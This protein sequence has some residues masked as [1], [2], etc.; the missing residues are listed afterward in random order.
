MKVS[1]IFVSMILGASLCTQA[2]A[3]VRFFSPAECEAN[4]KTRCHVGG[5]FLVRSALDINILATFDTKDITRPI[6]LKFSDPDGNPMP[7]W[8]PISIS[9]GDTE[10]IHTNK[11]R[12]PR[13]RISRPTNDLSLTIEYNPTYSGDRNCEWVRMGTVEF[14]KT[15]KDDNYKENWALFEIHLERELESIEIWPS[16]SGIRGELRFKD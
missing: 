1:G 3:N 9:V 4:A 7:D 16:L 15:R 5:I 8:K 13:L 11:G 14:R 10:I 12:E 6:R 2:K